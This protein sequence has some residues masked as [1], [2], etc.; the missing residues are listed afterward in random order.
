LF[1]VAWTVPRLASCAFCTCW[2]LTIFKL[3]VPG[4]SCAA[5]IERSD[6]AANTPDAIDDF[7]MA[8]AV[9]VG[10]LN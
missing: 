4:T 2:F 7:M 9:F 6:E 3:K 8:L 10:K 5:T 1:S